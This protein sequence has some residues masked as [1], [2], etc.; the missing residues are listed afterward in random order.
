[1][2]L[3]THSMSLPLPKMFLE[4]PFQAS[5]AFKYVLSRHI[6]IF[7]GMGLSFGSSQVIIGATGV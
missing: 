5:H 4:M 6:F 2:K 1:M 7:S 3:D